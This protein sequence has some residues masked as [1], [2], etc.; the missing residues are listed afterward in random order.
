MTLAEMEKFMGSNEYYEGIANNTNSKTNS[1]SGSNSGSNSGSGSSTQVV[2][3][4]DQKVSTWTNPDSGLVV[5]Y[6]PFDPFATPAPVATEAP[7][8]YLDSLIKDVQSGTVSQAQ[9]ET[10]LK[11]H[12]QGYADADTLVAEGL[13]YIQEQVGPE[14]TEMPEPSPETT[15]TVEPEMPQEETGGPGA[16]GWIIGA[17][18]LLAAAGGGYAVYS[19][20][21]RARKAA[22][23]AAQ[24]RAAQAR[25]QQQMGTGASA[26][27]TAG[28]GGNAG[29]TGAAGT[30]G[31][32]GTAGSPYGRPAGTAGTAA[33]AGKTAGETSGVSGAAVKPAA[34]AGTAGTTASTAGATAAAAGASAVKK[35]YENKVENP[36]GRYSTRNAGE[37]EAKYTASFRP[38]EN[39]AEGTVRRRRRTE[40]QNRGT[41]E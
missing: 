38:E 17:A 40:N 8:E 20:K 29:V 23:A 19:N 18:A 10:L 32:T 5:S 24:K 21:L 37:E 36:Y 30:A 12:Y 16:A 9:L 2:S 7:N 22:Q 15:V 13:K 25:R 39:A 33:T 27:K 34:T 11:S 26:G 28:A 6:E 35:P 41:E 14:E 3:A 4:E 1:S 31:K